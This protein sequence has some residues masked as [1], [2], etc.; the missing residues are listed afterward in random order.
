MGFVTYQFSKGQN[1]KWKENEGQRAIN[2]KWRAGSTNQYRQNIIVL[3]K[4]PELR[5]VVYQV[6]Y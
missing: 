2:I 6:V 3:L 4:P 1:H 5:M